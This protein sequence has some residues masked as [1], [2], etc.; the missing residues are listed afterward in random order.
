MN[1]TKNVSD[2]ATRRKSNSVAA[3]MASLQGN[4]L[5]QNMTTR[6]VACAIPATAEPLSHAAQLGQSQ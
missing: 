1:T 4:K 2:A 5:V 3:E 6:D